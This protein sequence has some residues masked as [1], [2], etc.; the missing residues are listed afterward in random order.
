[1]CRARN[2]A[3]GPAYQTRR[4]EA[5]VVPAGIVVAV[6]VMMLLGCD[7]TAPLQTGRREPASSASTLADEASSNVES[8]VETAASADTHAACVARERNALSAAATEAL[9]ELGYDVFADDLCAGIEALHARDASRCETIASSVLRTACVRRVAVLRHEP[10]LCPILDARTGREPLC[11]A[12]ASRDP[13]LCDLVPRPHGPRCL[14]VL[15]DDPRS[16]RQ[17]AELERV[18]CESLVRR[19]AEA[20]QGGRRE[21]RPI[22]PSRVDLRATIDPS[23]A[24]PAVFDRARELGLYVQADG[25]AR[26]VTFTLLSQGAAFATLP[27]PVA[28]RVTIPLR[29]SAPHT[30]TSADGLSVEVTGLRAERLDARNG[31]TGTVRVD[32]LRLERAAS[33]RLSFD[34]WLRGAAERIHLTGGVELPIRDLD[35][36]P[37]HCDEGKSR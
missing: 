36:L 7:E 16:C 8:L 24:A 12:W 29:S 18:R 32:S 13:R 3:S 34:L 28:M 37:D 9:D 21:T 26:S 5:A 17:P 23:T 30:L 11:V 15:R 4:R 6:I 22:T 1:M 19:F 35:P 31:S 2:A 10:D 27:G 25:C 14:A 33:L 20:T